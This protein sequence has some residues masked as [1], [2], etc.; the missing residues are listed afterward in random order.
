MTQKGGRRT[1]EDNNRGNTFLFG[2]QIEGNERQKLFFLSFEAFSLIFRFLSLSH[3]VPVTDCFYQ[4]S[5]MPFLLVCKWS[6]CTFICNFWHKYP[7]FFKITAKF[8]YTNELIFD[9][10]GAISV[11]MCV[12]GWM[13][14]C[15][16]KFIE[17]SI[18]ENS[19]VHSPSFFQAGVQQ[20][21]SSNWCLSPNQVYYKWF[22]FLTWNPADAHTVSV[23]DL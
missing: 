2:Y 23:S 13:L 10:S 15:T 16:G 18:D 22:T 4:R 20:R 8:L 7:F 3:T 9:N 5:N 21:N 17:Y 14:T 12:N 6:S 1:Q 11:W 19:A